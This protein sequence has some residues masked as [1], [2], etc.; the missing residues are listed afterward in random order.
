MQSRNTSFD[1]FQTLNISPTHSC[2]HLPIVVN[3]QETMHFFQRNSSLEHFV[4]LL[5]LK[6]CVIVHLCHI[7]FE[8]LETKEPINCKR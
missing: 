7:I 8:V 2:Q 1:F 3:T 4:R 6:T 5:P